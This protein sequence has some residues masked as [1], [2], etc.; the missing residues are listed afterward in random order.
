VQRFSPTETELAQNRQQAQALLKSPLEALE[1]FKAR[2]E[3]AM[4]RAHPEGI[5]DRRDRE[6][7]QRIF[8]QALEPDI[9][10]EV[11][12]N[13]LAHDYS[14]EW[15]TWVQSLRPFYAFREPKSAADND[16]QQLRRIRETNQTNALIT[17]SNRVLPALPVPFV[18]SSGETVQA[19]T[20]DLD[21]FTTPFADSSS[22]RDSQHSA[23]RGGRGGRGGRQHER[24]S[25]RG[26]QQD[27]YDSPP[28]SPTRPA[29]NPGL[30]SAMKQTTS[31]PPVVKEEPH[32]KRARVVH[33]R[34]H[35]APGSR[36]E[37]AAANSSFAVQNSGRSNAPTGKDRNGQLVYGPCSSCGLAHSWEYCYRNPKSPRFKPDQQSLKGLAPIAKQAGYVLG[38]E[39]RSNQAGQPPK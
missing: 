24:G 22:R 6:E 34:R 16:A 8:V 26:R 7:W 14:T 2:F 15:S 37:D 20:Y 38:D 32:A 27:E 10:R 1:T 29:A 33:F 9:I 11:N 35:P 39:F 21:P 28:P 5:R 17:T 30:R 4:H 36:Y 25:K 3:S 18:N 12:R 13:T 19:Y 31:P 23:G